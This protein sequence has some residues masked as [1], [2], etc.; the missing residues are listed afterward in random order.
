MQYEKE[1]LLKKKELYSSQEFSNYNLTTPSK[2][3]NVSSVSENFTASK[4]KSNGSQ[5]R[6]STAQKPPSK[7]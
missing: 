5:I 1:Q 6:M 4:M 2:K 3:K 7:L